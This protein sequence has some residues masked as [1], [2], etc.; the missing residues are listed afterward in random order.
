M[1]LISFLLGAAWVVY[2]V[3]LKAVSGQVTRGG[4][5]AEAERALFEFGSDLRQ[6]V[7]VKTAQAVTLSVNADINSD[8]LTENIQYTWSGISST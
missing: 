5:T 8:G 1:L 6:A 2:D 7:F 3:G 4:I